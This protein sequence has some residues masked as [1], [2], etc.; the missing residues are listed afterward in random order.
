MPFDLEDDEQNSPRARYNTLE[1][2][3]PVPAVAQSNRALSEALYTYSETHEF[4]IDPELALTMWQIVEWARSATPAQIE[5][6]R[7]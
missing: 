3:L 4:R 2:G 7:L 1:A 5:E 6:I